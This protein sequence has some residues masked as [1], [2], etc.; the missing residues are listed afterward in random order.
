MYS[1][2]VFTEYIGG[3]TLEALIQK[4]ERLEFLRKLVI[5]ID[6]AAAMVIDK[7]LYIYCYRSV[8]H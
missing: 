6:I 8:H 5:T 4:P 3:G 1:I 7:M 2:F